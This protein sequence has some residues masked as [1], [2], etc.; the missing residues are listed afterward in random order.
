MTEGKR[1]TEKRQGPSIAANLTLSLVATT[2]I[3]IVAV[4]GTFT[5]SILRSERTE[6]EQ[7]AVTVA[8]LAAQS[9]ALPMWFLHTGTI[10]EIGH[11][12]SVNEY[13]V[14]LRIIGNAGEVLYTYSEPEMSG[15]TVRVTRTVKYKGTELGKVEI[16]LSRQVLVAHTNRFLVLGG[17][18]VV[19]VSL[20]LVVLTRFYLRLFLD[21]PVRELDSM[22]AG[23][24]AGALRKPVTN[25][26]RELAGFVKTFGVM[27]DRI[28]SQVQKLGQTEAKYRSLFENALEGMFLSKGRDNLVTV[29]PAM[30]EMLGYESP[31]ELLS[32]VKDDPLAIIGDSADR[33]Q[34]YEMMKRDGQVTDYES[35][36]KRKDGSLRWFRLEAR[37]V[38]ADGE[39]LI[40]GYCQDIT[41]Q[42]ETRQALIKAKEEAE[43]ANQLKSDF[44]SMV[45]HEL[46]T[47]LTSILGFSK[48][49]AKRLEQ[50]IMPLAV[51]KDGD[52]A[53]AI[54]QM[55]D[56]S[57]III[58][59]GDRLTRLINNVLDLA[60][61]EAGRLDLNLEKH[62]ALDMLEQAVRT[63]RALFMDK[64]VQVLISAEEGLPM[65]LCDE[66]RVQQVLINLLSNAARFMTEGTVTCGARQEGREVVLSVADQGVGIAED[67]ATHLFDKFRQLGDTVRDAGAG[68]GLGLAISR[69]LVE[70]HG[71][72]IWYDNNPKGGCVFSFSL[73]VAGNDLS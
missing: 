17:L 44:L 36:F 53:R 29:N 9:L 32:Y 61:L 24:S 57:G 3:V 47:P 21:R 71:G 48:L 35:V 54:S 10:G 70:R 62:Q 63:T 20:A 59:E 6:L 15:G 11:A 55:M 43:A 66:D 1:H 56:Q 67:Q 60:K 33:E 41:R 25:P 22:V 34:Y 65:I 19:L 39:T 8:D 28:Q 51:D 2:I 68:T 45:S 58:A 16:A 23:Y 12:Y 38:R 73:P 52:E 69:E 27:A 72:R 18:V 7:Q 40:Q 13:V 4:I 42:V 26:P 50:D 5:F 49:I 37:Q 31:E 46:R 30:A 64:G 14:E